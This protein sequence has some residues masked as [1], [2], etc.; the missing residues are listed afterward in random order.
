MM[1]M[2]GWMR[3]LGRKALRNVKRTVKKHGRNTMPRYYWKHAKMRILRKW[4]LQNASVRTK[5][6]FQG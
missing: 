3:D 6:I 4:N 1:W 5:D 2:P